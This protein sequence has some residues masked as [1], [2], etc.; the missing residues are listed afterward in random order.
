ME[1]CIFAVD[2]LTGF[3]VAFALVTPAK[4]LTGVS[5]EMIEKKLK[6]KSFAAKVNRQEIDQ[7]VASLGIPAREH[8]QNVLSSMQLIHDKLG[9]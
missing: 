1:K 9:L 7:G 2:E 5:V 3:I 8:Y 6:Q 4:K